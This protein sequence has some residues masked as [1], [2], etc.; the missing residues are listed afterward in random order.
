MIQSEKISTTEKICEKHGV[1]L[2]YQLI[3]PSQGII[4]A[5]G[6]ET[7]TGDVYEW[8]CDECERERIAAANRIINADV[9]VRFEHIRQPPKRWTFEQP[10]TKQWVENH[11]QGSVLNLFAGKVKLDVNEFR[12]DLSPEFHPDL[13]SDA[14]QAVL[15]FI[16]LGITFD[17][18]ILDPPYSLRQSHEKY[19]GRTVSQFRKVMDKIPMILNSGGLV[20]S[21]G[22]QSAPMSRS[23]GFRLTDGLLVWHGGGHNNT[24]VSVEQFERNL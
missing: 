8:I 5:E 22:Y 11:L 14:F 10:Q 2:E 6:N 7:E 4:D 19:D 3:M 21:L 24:I 23:R 12:V 15:K 9:P 20:I 13:V 17:C 16:A 1:L 18:V